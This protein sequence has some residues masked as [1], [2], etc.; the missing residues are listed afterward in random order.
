[1]GKGVRSGVLGTPHRPGD[2]LKAPLPRSSKE[3]IEPPAA[4]SWT[5]AETQMP[6]GSA[7][8]SRRAATLTPSQRCRHPRRRCRPGEPMRTQFVCQR[9]PRAALRHRR[10]HLA[11]AAKRVD[12]ACELTKSPSPVVL[13]MRPR[14][15]TTFGSASSRRITCS[16]PSVPSSSSRSAVNSR[17]HRR[18]D[19]RDRRSTR[20]PLKVP[21]LQA[22]AQGQA[23]GDGPRLT[24]R[25]G[26]KLI[27]CSGRLR[28]G[29][30]WQ[31]PRQ[32]GACR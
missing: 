28:S 10:L 32:H 21:S 7:K 5:R 29:R 12:N 2:V 6:P 15:S 11:S 27:R 9:Q 23:A 20:P 26:R 18:R 8:P 22:T 17:R 30:C 25:L 3:E 13:T 19:G 4:S 16:A 14:C 31:F 1:V 24:L